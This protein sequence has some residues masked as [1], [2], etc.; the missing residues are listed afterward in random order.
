M[1]PSIAIVGMACRYPDAHSPIELWEN[2]LAQRRAFRRIPPERLR[3]EDYWSSDR[4]T[5]DCTYSTQAALIEGYEFDRAR[6]QIAGSTFRSTDLT[7]WLA[8][9]VASQALEDAGFL[10]GKG[11]PREA[12]RVI[13][14]NT[15]TG[16]FSR[17][18][19]LRLRW[20]Y[21]RRTVDAALTARQWEPIQRKAFLDD[22]EVQFKAPFA[23]VGEDTLA[24][25]LSNTIAGRICNYFDLRGGGYTV[26]GACCSSLL[27]VGDICS[28]LVAGDIDVGL[29]GGVDLSI[30][31][32][33]LVGFAK[34][35]ALAAE[36]MRVYDAHSEGFWPGEGCGFLVLMR[37]EDAMA[38]G[39]RA[40]ALV[41]GWGV[42]SDG[43]GGLTR[44]KVE[45]QRLALRR[46]YNRAGF[47]IGTVDLFEGH[48]TGTAVGDEVELEALSTARS[49]ARPDSPPAVIGSIKGNIGHTKGA[50]GIA[51][52]IKATLALHNQVLPPSAGCETLHPQ[53][54][55][56]G[57]T[58]RLLFQAEAWNP[59]RPLRAG[60]SSMGFGGINVHVV[61]EGVAATRRSALCAHEIHLSSSFQ[62]AEIF[63]FGG[64]DPA[65]LL[66]QLQHILTLARQLSVGELGD[67]A[68]QLA[69]SLGARE[70]RAAIVARKP[71]DL[72]ESLGK[73]ADWL[74]SGLTKRLDVG[75]GIF[76]GA[77]S[78]APRITFL[79]PGQG[80]PTR[81][82]GGLMRRRFEFVRDLY[83]QACF[84]TDRETISAAAVQPAIITAELAAL[85]VLDRL[86]I[87]A[88]AAVGHSLGELAALHW[89]GALDEAS[90]LRIA[91]ARGRAMA[92]LCEPGGTMASIGAGPAEVEGLLKDQAVTLACFN[93]PKQTVVSGEVSAVDVVV[94]RA[95]ARG[96]QAVRLP[97]TH[98]FH[99]ALVAPAAQSLAAHLDQE[100]FLPLRRSVIST[101]TGS[102]LSRGEDL[103]RLLCRQV[104]EPVRFAQALVAAAD[105]TDLF[106]DVGPGHVLSQLA[107]ESVETPGV[108]VD[109]CGSSLSGL[110]RAAA[111]A[112]ALGTPVRHQELFASR[113]TRPFDL[114]WHPKFF[115]NPCE[116][117]PVSPRPIENA[118]TARAGMDS[119]TQPAPARRPDDQSGPK[120]NDAL[121]V[122]RQLVAEQA[123][124]PTAAVRE[125]S[126]MLDDLH[127]NSIT[128]G[129]LVAEAARHL[130][131]APPVAPTDYAGVT[132]GEAARALQTLQATGATGPS[133][134]TDSVPK[135]VAAWLRSFTIELVERSL[136]HGHAASDEGKWQVIASP[137]HPLAA[138]LE[139]AF[140][141]CGEGSGTVVC[142]PPEAD[143]SDSDSVISILLQ[144]ADKVLEVGPTRFILVQQDGGAASFARTLHLE[145]PQVTT[146]VVDVPFDHPKAVEWIIAESLAA[147]N[148][149]EARYDATG[150]R[151]QPFLRLLPQ[152]DISELPL[153]PS[154]VLLVTGGGKGIAAECA[155]SLAR[156]SGVRLAL[157]GRSRPAT[158]AELAANLERLAA[159]GVCF[160]Y[161]VADVTDARAVCAAIE[162]AERALG[163]VTSILHGAGT[164][165]PRLLR[166]HN[167]AAF[168]KTI[169]TKVQGARNVLAAVDPARLR[170]L[171]MFGSIIS[172]TGM[173]GE[174]DY[175][176]ANEWLTRLTERWQAQHP[177]CR[178][179]AV[180][181]SVWSGVGMGERLG[182]V[183]ALA[184]QGITPISPDDGTRVL[185]HLLS[186]RLPATSVVVTGRFGEAPTLA[187]DGPELPLLR[188]LERPRV[189]Y[190]GVELVVD[191]QVSPDTDPYLD[192]HIFQG[193]KLFPAVMGL[194]AMAEAATFLT[195][196]PTSLVFEDVR[197]SRP[198]AVGDSTPL[199]LR[200]AALVREPG[201]VDVVLRS[202]ETAFQV[203]HFKATCRFEGGGTPEPDF[204]PG[205]VESL[206]RVP[207]VPKRDLYG[208][209]L[210]QAG[211][212]RRLQCYRRL[213]AKECI[214]EIASTDQN[215]GY[216][217]FARYL[218]ATLALGD[219]GARDAV[220]HAIQ[221]C[222]PN[223][224]ILP[225][226][227]DR[228]SFGAADAQGPR[229]VHAVER[230]R[231]NETFTYDLVVTDAQ[232]GLLERWEGLQL[233]IMSGKANRNGQRKWVE[234][235]LGP[236][237]ERRLEDLIPGVAVSVAVDLDH[238][239]E[240]RARS[241]R[242][243][244]RALGEG[245]KVWR[246]PDGKPHVNGDRHVSA[247]HSGDITLAVAGPG[248]VGCDVEC[249]VARPVGGWRDLLGPDR[250]AL[251]EVVAREASEDLDTSA[252]RVWAVEECLKKTGAIAR[253]PLVLTSAASGGWV[254]MSTGSAVA[255]TLVTSVHS[256]E[257]R[258]AFAVLAGS[259]DGRL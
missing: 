210:F 231:E 193:Q 139:R 153:G 84:P 192:D 249:V 217:W 16:E 251:A 194:E 94:A 246:R 180:E 26:D 13:V 7:H 69:R 229:L 198:I 179:L 15:L 197:F 40:Y 5:P 47:G 138:P 90:L 53:L 176:L 57:S 123:E 151:F 124:L 254:V 81:P 107:G 166:T 38:L 175:A 238:G 191:S 142:L 215:D 183:D 241:D 114:N 80:S 33:E 203:D 148:F 87:M 145:A 128:V 25:G 12:T 35:A 247:A 60:V 140:A 99:S 88:S 36:E 23:P 4:Q 133:H 41:R 91:T 212:F 164:N 110:L 136:T 101:V 150:R 201:R 111:A 102:Q 168:L 85:R 223:A 144:G 74:A 226:G 205:P 211:R 108:A 95:Q 22:L 162:E 37:H 143:E 28:A 121:A 253:G 167:Q 242:A 209:L 82:T 220:I 170:L 130:G 50:A 169:T 232:G 208:G 49:E 154:D 243:I 105:E 56:A 39:L 196:K 134:E 71:V 103:C 120:A 34:S 76:L 11:L 222:V 149:V 118:P 259:C 147:S 8:L 104:T 70:V 86:G 48:G 20:P 158:D 98:A 10:D 257:A 165:V 75:S 146:C 31:P 252:T 72:A 152:G 159:A 63:F 182:R 73:L 6:F 58:L 92:D 45:G 119:P 206:P 32:F 178:C 96:W 97:V 207:I 132:V 24:G 112:F 202:S 83:A 18:S 185:R 59:E 195:G 221:A 67:L 174:A 219:P 233:R 117:A 181:W 65:D 155:F 214:A 100:Q 141:A 227:V 54:S 68:A 46:A 184:Q 199:T 240:R 89:A 161:V 14:G 61:L 204:R 78:G 43:C 135:G 200:T 163:H 2:V 113:F 230:M 19:V 156:E 228:I 237:M 171:V 79:F 109:A 190:P 52:V 187:V 160:R 137:A 127:L 3:L 256:A 42:S 235:L 244:Q 17:A 225:I 129:R 218:P 248:N 77:G 172:R 131:L 213:A 44:P 236:Y 66:H 21:V 126:R 188:F 255:A 106:I 116:L 64:S 157:L 250:F 122:I 51:G 93:S 258:L 125:D 1:T 115:V 173:R 239:G 177:R 27:A 30:D 245:V 62:D 224:V 9:N 29:A 234:P 216:A 189:Y 55:R 186:Q